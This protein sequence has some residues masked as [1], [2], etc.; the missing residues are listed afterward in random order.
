VTFENR[1]TGAQSFL[2]DFGDGE[3]SQ[4]PSPAHVYTKVSSYPVTLQAFGPGGS[5]VAEEPD[6]IAVLDDVRADF[7][8]VPTKGRAPLSVSFANQSTGGDSYRWDF[9]DGETIAAANP[10][11]IYRVGGQYTVTLRALAP[12]GTES[13]ATRPQYICVDGDLD[14][15]FRAAP[16]YGAPPLA[17]QFTDESAGIV[18]G[19]L[20]DFGDGQTSREQSPQHTY[21]EAGAYT[22]TLEV[23]GFTAIDAEAKAAYICV[24][25]GT[26][27][28]RGDA[29][30]DG[31]MD[32]SDAVRI[33]MYL[34]GGGVTLDCLDAADADDSGALDISDPIRIL[35]YLYL[36][37]QVVAPP[38]PGKGPDP[39]EDGLGCQR[40]GA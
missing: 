7:V 14:A 24:G 36:G 29:N 35:W 4:E 30:V 26:A 1:S 21:V 33:L 12:D 38:F 32:I 20:W 13:T 10:T 5:D 23:F 25:P 19:W 39:T 40:W 6:C 3:T 9:G 22:V 34:F 16:L 2:W 8:A 28:A 17:L 37:G 18:T 15:E 11:H 27:F 31:R